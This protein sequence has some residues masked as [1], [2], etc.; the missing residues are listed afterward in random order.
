[1]HPPFPQYLS[2]R[3]MLAGAG[4]GLVLPGAFGRSW[5][6]PAKGGVLRVCRPD[7]PDMLDPMANNSISAEEFSRIV[8]DRLA[9]LDQNDQPQ[10]MLATA[11]QPEKHGQEWVVTLREDVTFHDGQS[12]TSANVVATMERSLDKAKAGIGFQAFGPVKAVKAEGSHKVRVVLE[13]P[14]GEFPVLLASGNCS[15]LPIK[16]IDDLRQTPNGTGPYLFKD[17]QPGQSVTL[18]RNPRFWNPALQHLDGIRL[19]YIREAVAMQAALRGGLVDV[20]TQLPAESYLVLSRMAGVRA[21]STGTGNYQTVQIQANMA[22]FNNPKVRE[23]FR[24]IPDRPAVLSAAL[25]GQGQIGNDVSL[26]PGNIYLPDLTQWKQDLPR[27]KK[28]IEEAGVGP[29]ELE[30]FTTSDRQPAPKMA[31]AFSEAAAKVGIKLVVR[32]I[33]FTEYAA[34]VARKKP[35]YTANFSAAPTLYSSIW[36]CYHSKG[37]YNYSG[38]EL[39]PGFDS[40]I[41]ALNGAIDLAERKAI[42]ADVL[43]VIHESNDRLIPYFR[44]YFAATSAKVGGFIPPK[45]GVVEARHLWLEA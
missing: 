8:Y 36:R 35:L 32:D 40:K 30:F 20:L 15:I 24:Y 38:V 10:P 42:A 29:I 19:V 26:P 23:A 6:A 31:L 22:P 25:F 11:W 27:A 41:D 28:L 43:R 13:A 3:A 12:F 5:A 21:Y 45:F 44:N 39:A 37:P 16:G 18:D 7:G 2:R 4:A 33:P 17:F 9:I 34:N 1:M 14:F